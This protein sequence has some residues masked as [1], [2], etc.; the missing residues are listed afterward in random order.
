MMLP[1]ELLRLKT[2]L[3]IILDEAE[4]ICDDRLKFDKSKQVEF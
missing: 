4:I 2:K 1:R 3:D